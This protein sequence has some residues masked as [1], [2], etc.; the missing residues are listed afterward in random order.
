MVVLATTAAGAATTTGRERPTDCKPEKWPQQPPSAVGHRAAP[1]SAPVPVP[2]ATG[3]LRHRPAA[4]P[5][6]ATSAALVAIRCHSGG[7]SPG[8]CR[9]LAT[10][11]DTPSPTAPTAYTDNDGPRTAADPPAQHRRARR[12]RSQNRRTRCGCQP[13]PHDPLPREE[14]S[15]L[16]RRV[17]RKP[18]QGSRGVR[19]RQHG[20]GHDRRASPVVPEVTASVV[21]LA[22]DRTGQVGRGGRLLPTSGDA[23]QVAGAGPGED[24]LRTFEASVGTG[25]TKLGPHE[26]PRPQ[27]FTVPVKPPV[28]VTTDAPPP[29]GVPKAN[30][31]T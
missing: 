16:G 9:A 22:A 29:A 6:G 30:T 19:E 24:R 23:D 18:P 14:P 8:R 7:S 12:S 1:P 10:R 15:Q 27:R 20:H 17:S 2:T 31:S 11:S 28:P 21:D 25:D 5:T 26:R 13:P 3:P 4:H